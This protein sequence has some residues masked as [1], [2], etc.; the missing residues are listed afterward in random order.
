MRLRGLTSPEFIN[1]SD[2]LQAC[3][4]GCDEGY[5]D[6]GANIANFQQVESTFPAFILGDDRVWHTECLRSV[7]PWLICPSGTRNNACNTSGIDEHDRTMH[8]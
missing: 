6:N 1:S 7:S 8:A 4:G 2:G 3:A 5:A